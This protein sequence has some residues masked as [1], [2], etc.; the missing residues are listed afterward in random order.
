M[1]SRRVALTAAGL[2]LAATLTACGGGSGTTGAAG[3]AS[4]APST[5]APATPAADARA[6]DVMFA[7]M[8]IPHHEQAVEMADLALAPAAGAGTD[9]TALAT[10]IKAAQAPEIAT[11]GGWLSAWGAE[12]DDDMGGMH[13]GASMPGMMSDEDMSAL[14]DAR[15]AAFDRMWLTMMVA[16]HEGALTMADDVLETTQD[17]QVRSLAEA[18]VSGQTAEI[19]TM[20]SLLAG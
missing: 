16:H 12:A 2:T 11:M 19:A 8:M 18:V 15:G 17:P 4:A 13:H 3:S 6:A 14:G 7:Q 10:R 20:K 9:V 5:A 1:S